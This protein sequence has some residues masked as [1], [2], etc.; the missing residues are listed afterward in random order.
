MAVTVL[1][2]SALITTYL[3]KDV[4]NIGDIVTNLLLNFGDIVTNLLLNF[5][6]TVTSNI[7]TREMTCDKRPNGRE[8]D[9]YDEH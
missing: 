9:N 5:G 2:L 8:K 7:D 4:Q 6:D 3:I 1:S